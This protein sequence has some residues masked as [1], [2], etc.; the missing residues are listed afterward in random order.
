MCSEYTM[1]RKVL[2]GVGTGA[3]Y[4]D[5]WQPTFHILPSNSHL[6]GSLGIP[7][8]SAWFLEV[9]RNSYLPFYKDAVKS[10]DVT[11]RRFRQILGND[12]RTRQITV[13]FKE[14]GYLNRFQRPSTRIPTL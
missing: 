5:E 13:L 14:P 12:G 1:K 6:L 2:D 11:L 7:S 3:L 8:I 4:R 9:M 10:H